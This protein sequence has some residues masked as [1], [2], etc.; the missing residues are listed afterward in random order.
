MGWDLR[1]ER[2]HR[3]GSGVYFFRGTVVGGADE[4]C[5]IERSAVVR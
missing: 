5:K 4:I 3:V 1:D 2:G